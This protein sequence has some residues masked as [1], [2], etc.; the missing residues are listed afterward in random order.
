MTPPTGQPLL[1]VTYLEA[2][3]AFGEAI[4]LTVPGL[5]EVFV[6]VE[7][8]KLVPDD[9]KLSFDAPKSIDIVREELRDTHR[10]LK[11]DAA[12]ARLAAERA[13]VRK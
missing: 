8:N 3:L 5:G 11:L 13:K 2:T 12:R 6:R 10:Q 7:P 9:V 1:N 4:L